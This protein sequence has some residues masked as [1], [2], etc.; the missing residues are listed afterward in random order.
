MSDILKIHEIADA[1]YQQTYSLED[2]AFGFKRTHN[3]QVADE[4]LTTVRAIRALS[5]AIHP[6]VSNEIF[7]G[8]KRADQSSANVLNAALAGIEIGSKSKDQLR[9]TRKLKETTP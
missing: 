7:E 5:E 6:I 2:L 9:G 4:I 1:I 3:E 8:V